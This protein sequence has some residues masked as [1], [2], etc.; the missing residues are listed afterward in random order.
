[1]KLRKES[2]R[3]DVFSLPFYCNQIK[4]EYMGRHVTHM[5]KPRN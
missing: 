2:I 1:M 3:E 5:R 4:R